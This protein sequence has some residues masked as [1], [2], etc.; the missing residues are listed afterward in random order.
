MRPD[1]VR[2]HGAVGSMYLESGLAQ[3][4]PEIAAYHLGAAGRAVEAVSLWQQAGRNARKNARFQEAAGHEREVLRLVPRLPED[5]R[6]RTELKTRSRLVICLTAVDQAHPETLT[7]SERVEELAR[8]LGDRTALLR[9]YMVLVPWWQASAAYDQLGYIL[10]R[11]RRGGRGARRR[12][13]PP[14]DRHVRGDGADLAGRGGGR[15]G[16]HPRRFR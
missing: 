5:E 12:M 9:N 11:A 7:E 15:A 1:R 2:I 3:S 13:V 10:V 6:D 8:Q 16:A 14:R 4:R